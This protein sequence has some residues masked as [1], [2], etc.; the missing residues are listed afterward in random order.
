MIHVRNKSALDE[1]DLSDAKV[2]CRRQVID[3]MEFF[4]KKMPQ[5]RHAVL[6]YTPQQIEVRESS[7]F[8]VNTFFLLTTFCVGFYL[9]FIDQKL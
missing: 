5:F 9:F 7:I 6:R 1:K 3:I 8:R 2:E 4:T